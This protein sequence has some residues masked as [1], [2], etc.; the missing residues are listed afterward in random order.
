MT[1]SGLAITHYMDTASLTERIKGR[2][3]YLSGI[4]PQA[5]C[6]GGNDSEGYKSRETRR[7]RTG[8]F[9]KHRIPPKSPTHTKH[10]DLHCNIIW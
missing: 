2:H 1:L 8:R 6:V 9:E 10:V 7:I 5:V 3:S 4:S